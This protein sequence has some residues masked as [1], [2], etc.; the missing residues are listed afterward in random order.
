MDSPHVGGVGSTYGGNPLSCVAA[1]ESLKL[2]Q[3]P[4]AKEGA[5]RVERIVREIFGNLQKEI[6]HLGDVRGVG[7]MMAIEFVKDPI[8]K[9]PWTDLVPEIVKGCLQ[10]G[11]IVLRAG[12]YTNCIRFLPEVTIPEDV[13]REALEVVAASARAA[14][15][16]HAH[17]LVKVETPAL[18]NA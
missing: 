15:A 6:P 3:K 8:T 4:E 13:L 12:L 1:L 18:V 5:A 10:R 16:A 7:G 17:T 14:V 11:V 2:L 9:E